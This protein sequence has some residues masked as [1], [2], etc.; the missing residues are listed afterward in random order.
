MM[1]YELNNM[2]YILIDKAKEIIKRLYEK[3]KHHIGSAILTKYGK[4]ITSVHIEAYVES[5]TLCTEAVAVGKAISEG[6]RALK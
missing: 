4:I 3:D 2:D 5:V 1:I 6:E